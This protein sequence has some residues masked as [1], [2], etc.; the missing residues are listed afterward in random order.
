[1]KA[2]VQT[3]K[4]DFWRSLCRHFLAAASYHDENNAVI[5][6]LHCLVV[7]YQQSLQ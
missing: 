3:L 4:Y 1:M 6:L 5:E 2:L 7:Q